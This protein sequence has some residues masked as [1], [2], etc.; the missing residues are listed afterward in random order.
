VAVLA[1]G[2]MGMINGSALA[3]VATTGAITIPLMKQS[4]YRAR[5]AAAVEAVASTGGQFAPPIMGAVGFVMAEYL[6]VPYVTVLIAAII[7]AFLYY[8]TLIMVVHF[9]AKKMGLKGISKDIIRAIQVVLKDRGYLLIPLVVLL[10][11]LFTGY[12]DVYA[13][14]Y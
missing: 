9:E 10:V 5:F 14:V 3:N 4:G 6:G 2:L 8:L 12:T 1:S 7:P 11:M 13:G